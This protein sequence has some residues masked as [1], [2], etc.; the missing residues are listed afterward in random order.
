[1]DNKEQN[2]INKMGRQLSMDELEQVVGGGDSY[3]KQ[4]TDPHEEDF[5][6]VRDTTSPV[7]TVGVR[8]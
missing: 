4:M 6:T 1:M 5:I 2:K 3:F 7:D 8:M